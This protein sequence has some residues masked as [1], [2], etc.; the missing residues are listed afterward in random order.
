[1]S[2]TNNNQALVE[3]PNPSDIVRRNT[4]AVPQQVQKQQVAVTEPVAEEMNQLKTTPPT[5]KAPPKRKIPR[6]SSDK[7][8]GQ[9]S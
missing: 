9:P 8:S 2:D 6:G 5:G 7:S 1:M 4:G 3:L